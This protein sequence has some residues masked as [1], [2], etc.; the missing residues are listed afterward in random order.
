MVGAVPGG[1]SLTAGGGPHSGD[2][3]IIIENLSYS[4]PGT[5]R[6]ALRGVDLRF[7]KGRFYAVLGRNGSGKSTLARCLNALLVPSGGRVLSCGFDTADPAGLVEIRRRLAMV[8]QDPDTQIV[9]ISVEEEVAFGPENLG[10]PP[11]AI[12]ERVDTALD[13]AGI[14]DLSTRQP[15]RL[16]QGQKQLVALA[17]ALAMEPAFLLSD[18]STSM[19]DFGA[20]LRI[21]DLFASLTGKGVGVVHVTHFLE[22]A[23]LADEVIVLDGGRVAA[24]GPPAEVLCDPDGVAAMGLDPLPVTLV[25][26]ELGLL[27]H[28]AP[29]DLL[30]VK[31]LLSWL[32]A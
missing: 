16:S 27:G 32:S 29:P 26:R 17:G 23:S 28:P 14:R 10:L 12:R 25:A 8:F 9:G 11:E 1:S 18:E 5:A 7:E 4:Y 24:V 22:E 2:A 30:T 20:R 21:L 6:P 19:L 15:L 13:M 3:S 31:E